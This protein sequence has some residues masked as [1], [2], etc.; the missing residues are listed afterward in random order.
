[1]VF[2][3]ILC[4]ANTCYYYNLCDGCENVKNLIKVYGNKT[5][6]DTL[7][8][9]L[10]RKSNAINKKTTQEIEKTLNGEITITYDAKKDE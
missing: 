4:E 10:V 2:K 9:V 7:D 8:N 5:V 1:M 6:Y 3:C